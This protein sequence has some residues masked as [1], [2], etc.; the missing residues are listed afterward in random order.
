MDKG[1]GGLNLYFGMSHYLKTKVWPVTAS[2]QLMFH[3]YIFSFF[4]YKWDFDINSTLAYYFLKL[5]SPLACFEWSYF[6]HI[7]FID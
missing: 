3:A 7:T 5:T 6:H 2:L 4:L 1:I